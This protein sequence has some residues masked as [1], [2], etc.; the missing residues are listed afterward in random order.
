[1][2]SCLALR[3]EGPGTHL[4]AADPNAPGSFTQ[5]RLPRL[6]AGGAGAA[7]WSVHVPAELLQPTI[8]PEGHLRMEDRAGTPRATPGDRA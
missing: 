3:E 4:A 2:R 8:E 7:F 5:A 6:A 1:V